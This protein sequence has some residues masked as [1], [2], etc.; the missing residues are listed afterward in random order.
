MGCSSKLY[1]VKKPNCQVYNVP[2]QQTSYIHL[3]FSWWKDT[4]S[5]WSYLDRHKMTMSVLCP[6]FYSDW[7]WYWPL[8]VGLLITK[9]KEGLSVTKWASKVCDQ[10]KT[11]KLGCV[12]AQHSTALSKTRFMF[13]FALHLCLGMKHHSTKWNYNNP[14]L[15]AACNTWDL[16]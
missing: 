12:Y 5:D 15:S 8:F 3:D 11:M 6:V 10:E 13:P 1:Y 2:T 14:I 16:K 4:Q 9:V 7:L